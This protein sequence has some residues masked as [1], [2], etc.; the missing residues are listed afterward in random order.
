M[1]GMNGLFKKAIKP[2]VKS[3][4][5]RHGIRCADVIHCNWHGTAEVI[6]STGWNNNIKTFYWGLHKENFNP[7]KKQATKDA[8]SFINSIPSNKVKFFFPKS[9]SPN[10]RHD[11]IVEASYRLI[12]KGQ[13]DFIVYLWLGNTNDKVII[14]ELKKKIHCYG[15]TNHVILQSHGFLPFAD[16]QLIWKKMDVGLQIAVNEQLSTTF[17]EPQFYRKEIIV[18]DII[19]YR[20]YNQLFSTQI[21]LIP[22]TA[23]GLELSMSKFINGYRTDQDLL[24][25]RHHIILQYFNME[26]NLEKIINY[27][28]V[29]LNQKNQFL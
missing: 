29:Q 26:R 25:K 2:S 6:R 18:S 4:M 28:T 5:F 27:Y 3:I 17:L 14:K 11:L 22:L 15:L 12:Q 9:I 8:E 7:A 21:E 13:S 24:E 10:S 1:S 23:E 16:M 19:P 20:I